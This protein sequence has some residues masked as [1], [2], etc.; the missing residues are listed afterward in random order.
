MGII[1]VEL[2]QKN[3]QVIS[4]LKMVE[5]LVNVPHFL[6]RFTETQKCLQIFILLSVLHFIPNVDD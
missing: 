2:R 3:S 5:Y 4:I 6:K 1:A